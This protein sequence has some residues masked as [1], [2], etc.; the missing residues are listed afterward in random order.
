MPFGSSSPCAAQ[1][2]Q[3][4]GLLVATTPWPNDG[5]VGYKSQ[6]LPC[7]SHTTAGHLSWES[8]EWVLRAFGQ[9]GKEGEKARRRRREEE[10]KKRRKVEKLP[11]QGKLAKGFRPR[12]W[13]PP[14]T[15]SFL[16]PHHHFHFF[17]APSSVS[18]TNRSCV[19]R[20][21]SRAT[22][23]HQ[24]KGLGSCVLLRMDNMFSCIDWSYIFVC[25]E[26]WFNDEHVRVMLDSKFCKKK[27]S[28]VLW[29][30]Y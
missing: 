10:K 13:T 28:K 18:L 16:L 6:P 7:I 4:R 5:K 1:A 25:I 2:T 3:S 21:T 23:D 27:G 26:L 17:L 29:S 24:G 22:R 11:C 15:T 9:E 8:E 19:N 12:P 20:R 30:I 14:C